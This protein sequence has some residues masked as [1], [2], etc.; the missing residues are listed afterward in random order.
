MNQMIIVQIILNKTTNISQSHFDFKR[1]DG[2]INGNEN[3][4]EMWILVMPI[5]EM[6]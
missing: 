4:R 6:N 3:S 2:N 5:L 1:L